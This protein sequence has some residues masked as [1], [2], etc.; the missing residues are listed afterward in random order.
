MQPI[1]DAVLQDEQV[2][3]GKSVNSKHRRPTQFAIK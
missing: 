3:N 1:R 2:T